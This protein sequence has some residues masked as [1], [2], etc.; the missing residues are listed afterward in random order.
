LDYK[1]SASTAYSTN[2]YH[3]CADNQARRNGPQSLS[4]QRDLTPQQ[5]KAK[6]DFTRDNKSFTDEGR[7]TVELLKAAIDPAH[8]DTVWAFWNITDDVQ[9]YDV[10]FRQI[11]AALRTHHRGTPTAIQT[12]IEE[13]DADIR[14][15]LPATTD[16]DAEKSFS[17][18]TKLLAERAGFDQVAYTAAAL[19]KLFST[20]ILRD[21]TRVL[22]RSIFSHFPKGDKS[23]EPPPPGEISPTPFDWRCPF[24]YKSPPPI[25]GWTKRKRTLSP[26]CI[27]PRRDQPLSD[28]FAHEGN[29]GPTEEHRGIDLK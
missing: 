3:N 21:T 10:T 12:A 25:E 2:N 4:R 5:V 8:Q 11:I 24:A 16:A 26:M 17:T 14:Q 19:R 9:S 28:H 13:I 15:I 29:K 6:A 27:D 22:V 20:Q 1:P 23:R 18:I 7:K